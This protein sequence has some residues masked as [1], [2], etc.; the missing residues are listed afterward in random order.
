MHAGLRFDLL[1]QFLQGR[2][3]VLGDRLPNHGFTRFQGA[4]GT[5]G[6]GLGGQTA[7]FTPETPPVFNG[8]IA[9][10]KVLGNVRLRR[11]AFQHFGNHAFAKINRVCIHG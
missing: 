4:G 11:P 5:G 3:G 6:T 2:I 10:V 8:R 9:N 7:R 1:A